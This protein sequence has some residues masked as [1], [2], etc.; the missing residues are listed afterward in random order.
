MNSI[1]T[2]FKIIITTLFLSLSFSA[3]ANNGAFQQSI[4]SSFQE[5]SGVGGSNAVFGKTGALKNIRGYVGGGNGHLR[6]PNKKLRLYV[7]NF[8]PPT[9]SSSCGKVSWSSGSMSFFKGD[10]GRALMQALEDIPSAALT[11]A[12]E[13]ALE[14]MCS[15]CKNVM[16]DIQAVMNSLNADLGNSCNV[17]TSIVK[18]IGAREDG[19]DTADIFGKIL[20]KADGSYMSKADAAKSKFNTAYASLSSNSK[21]AVDELKN[22]G[23]FPWL[24]PRDW[25]NLQDSGFASTQKKTSSDQEQD[26]LTEDTVSGK[27]NKQLGFPGN[28]VFNAL[29]G[30]NGLTTLLVGN[31]TVNETELKNA[32]ISIT[33]TKYIGKKA[34]ATGKID[35]TKD[36]DRVPYESL[37][38]LTQLIEGS[39]S[40]AN[41]TTTL[42]KC[43]GVDADT[44]CPLMTKYE[45]KVVGFKKIMDELWLGVPDD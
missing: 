20:D 34:D 39:G 12:F 40:G 26:K 27:N 16:K 18:G 33:G 36:V 41:D 30:N 45:S 19:D 11:Y 1:P 42:W 3:N 44:L 22:A 43:S 29:S 31:T 15:T 25:S 7:G 10:N 4:Q 5:Q 28:I 35:A 6:I 37:I 2:N 24:D 14:A 13:M 23:E 17:A 8:V 32:I 21:A 38:N 9:L